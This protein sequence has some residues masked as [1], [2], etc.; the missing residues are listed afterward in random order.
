MFLLIMITE[1]IY[2]DVH[3]VNNITETPIDIK[4]NLNHTFSRFSERIEA[5]VVVLFGLPEWIVRLLPNLR[6]LVCLL[7]ERVVPVI[8]VVIGVTKG[9][10][11]RFRR[12]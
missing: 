12:S 7:R 8:V 6:L 4:Q 9:I 10:R 11:A 5:V 3:A 2:F 1:Y